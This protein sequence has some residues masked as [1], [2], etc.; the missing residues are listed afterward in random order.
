MKSL[1]SIL[2]KLFFIGT[3]LLFVCTIVITMPG[4]AFAEDTFSISS[5][6][7]ITGYSGAGGDIE[8]P[9]TV[10]GTAVTGIGDYAFFACSGITSVSIP[11]GITGIGLS[12]FEGC[13]GLKSVTF[14]KGLTSIG[15]QPFDGC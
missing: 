13:T 3:I 9:S 11:E 2:N 15:D 1:K 7:V 12:A 14:P 8:V 6:G 4:E 5:A 10:N